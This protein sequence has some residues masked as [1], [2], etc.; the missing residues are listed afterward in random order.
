MLILSSIAI[1][2]STTPCF[3][4]SIFDFFLIIIVYLTDWLI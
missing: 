2:Y 4:L 1:Y 3:L